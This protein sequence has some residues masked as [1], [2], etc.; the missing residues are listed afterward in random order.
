MST[1]VVDFVHSFWLMLYLCLFIWL[2][3][4]VMFIIYIT[5]V[6]TDRS[7]SCPLPRES[8]VPLGWP[9]QSEPFLAG[10]ALCRPDA[11]PLVPGPEVTVI[12]L[13]L[14]R[15]QHV[16]ERLKEQSGDDE[17]TNVRGTKL[18]K[19]TFYIHMIF[20][21]MLSKNFTFACGSWQKSVTGCSHERPLPICTTEPVADWVRVQAR[22][23]VVGQHAALR[24]SLCRTHI[25][26][27]GAKLSNVKI[28]SKEIFG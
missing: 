13:E 11:K 10:E 20:K 19:I 12:Q 4:F 7:G 21:A 6:V 8:A 28:S 24:P 2:L 9:V 1:Y 22:A 17:R 25:L 5:M 14:S 26:T 18:F 16:W 3:L 15:A 27:F 23:A